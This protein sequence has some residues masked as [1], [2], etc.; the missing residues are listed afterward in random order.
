MKTIGMKLIQLSNRSRVFWAKRDSDQKQTKANRGFLFALVMTAMAINAFLISNCVA[1]ED[2]LSNKIS[3]VAPESC[4]SWYQWSNPYRA[5]A[6]SANAVDRMMAEPEVDQ[7]LT[8][9]VDKLGQLPGILVPEQAPRSI[10]ESAATLGPHLVNAILRKQGSVFVESFDLNDNQE[11]KNAKAGLVL[12][13]GDKAD[14]TMQAIVS[15]LEGVGA[16]MRKSEAGAQSFVIVQVPPDGPFKEVYLAQQSGHLMAATSKEMIG[17]M[18]ARFKAGK[19]AGW[20][21]ELRSGQSYQR[22]AGVGK[23]DIATLK[24]ML[25]PLGGPEAERTIKV[26]GLDNVKQLEMSAGYAKTDY[27][28]RFA[29]RFDGPPK[30]IF[31]ALSDKG[32]TLE[33]ISHFPEDSFLAAAMSVDGKKAFSEFQR[34]LIQLDPNSAREMSNNLIEFQSATG[35][36]LRGAI[37][38]LGPTFAIHN[39]FGDGIVSGA[40]LKASVEDSEDFESTI[41]NALGLARGMSSDFSLNVE[42]VEQNG[43]TIQQM[44]FG[45]VPVPVQPS[46]YLDGNQVTISLFPSV[47]SAVTNT[48]LVSPLVKSKS[49][50]PYLPLLKPESADTSVVGF[51]YSES[52]LSYEMVY[53]Y[54]CMV[55]AMGKNMM[56]GQ[57][58]QG[59][60]LTPQ[61]IAEINE[62]LSDLQIP[63]C[64]S[65]VRHLTP[66]VAVIRKESDAIVFESHSSVASGNVTMFAPGVA[67]GMLLPAVQQVR[68]AARRTHSANNLKQQSLAALNFESAH[69]HFPMGDGPVRK[70]GPPVSWRVKIL[71]FIEAN[72]VYEQYNVDEPW[73]SETNLKVLEKMPEVYNNPAS[74]AQPNHTV[75]RGIGGTSG[76]LGV[77]AEGESR[78]TNF[79]QITDGSSNTIF[80]LE[81]PDEMAVPW[82][83][84]DGGIDPEKVK[85]WQ[86]RGNHPGGFNAAFGDGS[87][88]FLPVTIDEKTFKSLM[89]MNDGNAVRGF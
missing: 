16:P 20:L 54:T 29:L 13:L 23:V 28:Q 40:M 88:H 12:E 21:K 44:Q 47:L 38:N 18:I 6:S 58:V 60:P 64:R 22:I 8:K 3:S 39:G 67:V 24:E 75:Y 48:D 66:Q 41:K 51:S 72:N 68:A 46:W 26:L 57:V 34:I 50:E 4:L 36:D 25:L 63:S 80:I 71:P 37:E 35:I 49:F 86:M 78:K 55:S 52:K 56:S 70:G 32:L 45:G 7:F 79:G 5:D 10:K 11:P 81:T 62:L 17:E 74:A 59:V 65:V 53:G 27:E 85:P 84:P 82:T 73:D 15:A 43:K 61:Q 2:T 69:M 9:L 76:I 19:I 33:D 14:E 89:M 83:K 77:D 31:K 1:Q 42:S 30:G 87:V